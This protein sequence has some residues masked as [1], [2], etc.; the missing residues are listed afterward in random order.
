MV[1]TLLTAFN[2]AIHQ[3]LKL[4]HYLKHDNSFPLD[5]LEVHSHRDSIV[6]NYNISW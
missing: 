2:Q 6:I 1:S 5:A 3:D 4:F